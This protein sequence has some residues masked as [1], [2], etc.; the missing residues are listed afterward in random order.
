M[1]VISSRIVRIVD[2]K[3]VV[4]LLGFGL[5]TPTSS[6]YTAK[7]LWLPLL[8]PGGRHQLLHEALSIRKSPLLHNLSSD[9]F[10]DGSLMDGHLFAVR[11][12]ACERA[13]LGSARRKP[14][15]DA[16]ALG[17][18]VVYILVPVGE[19]G[20]MACYLTLDALYSFPLGSPDKVADKV[21]GVQLICHGEVALAPQL[22]L[23]SEDD[24]FIVGQS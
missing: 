1:G 21:S 2:I 4:K 7:C 23:G 15:D 12:H 6:D 20:S 22:G 14:D 19:C 9:D 13:S 11:G 3:G 18:D 24:R 5:T 16:I 8:T 10:V 17:N